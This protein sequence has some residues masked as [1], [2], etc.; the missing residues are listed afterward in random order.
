[1]ER[2]SRQPFAS[3]VAPGTRMTARARPGL[4]AAARPPR[5]GW[6]ARMRKVG[7]RVRQLLFCLGATAGLLGGACS[8]RTSLG[9]SGGAHGG[10]TAQLSGGGGATASRDAGGV[11]GDG[12]APRSGG[13][14]QGVGAYYGGDGI[15]PMGGGGYLGPSLGGG[16]SGY[17]GG[18]HGGSGGMDT[19][20]I[21]CLMRCGQGNAVYASYGGAG[22]RADAATATT[23]IDSSSFDVSDDL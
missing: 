13:G 1:M 6:E 16:G 12:I 8:N 14:A 3:S 19:S 11:P 17:G 18:G 7:Q 10:G 15:A 4:T 23:P 21:N 22:G 20:S 9:G 5:M 2:D